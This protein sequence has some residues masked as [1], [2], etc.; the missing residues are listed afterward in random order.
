MTTLRVEQTA[1]SIR[2][3]DDR[4]P[5][6]PVYLHRAQKVDPATIDRVLADRARLR[7][8]AAADARW[9]AY[10]EQAREEVERVKV[11][12]GPARLAMSDA[13]IR[14]RLLGERETVFAE[15]EIRK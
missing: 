8:E 4:D 7:A 3:W 15:A 9:D 5:D 13:E 12:L 6:T 11:E 1:E 10:V 2:V 14:Q